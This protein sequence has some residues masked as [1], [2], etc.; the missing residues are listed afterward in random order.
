VFVDAWPAGRIPGFAADLAGALPPGRPER[1][2]WFG[3]QDVRDEPTVAERE[4]RPAA[5]AVEHRTTVADAVGRYPAYFQRPPVVERA[6]DGP[7]DHGHAPYYSLTVSNRETELVEVK[8][9][10]MAMVPSDEGV[11][12]S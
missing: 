4:C 1:R 8:R 7:A 12:F 5:S 10:V 6:G 11:R 9:P 3:A 2:P